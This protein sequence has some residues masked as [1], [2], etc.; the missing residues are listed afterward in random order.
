MKRVLRPVFL[1]ATVVVVGGAALV[2]QTTRTPGSEMAAAAN[3][4]LNSLTPELKQKASFA[5]DDPHRTAWFFTPQQDAMRQPTRKGVR[6]EELSAEQRTAVLALLK[7]GLSASGYDQATTIMSLESVLNTLEKNGRNVRNPNWYFVSIFGTPSTTGQWG[8]RFEGHHMSINFTLDKG[9]V[10]TATPTLFGANPAEI[11]SGPMQ[12]KRTLSA[13]EDHAKKLIASLSPQQKKK[14]LQPKQ[15]PEIQE[16]SPT[17]D[18]GPA[19][20]LP[21]AQLQADQQAIL[22]KLLEAYAGRLEK[23]VAQNELAAVKKAGFE[24]VTFAYHIAESAPGKPYTYR[25]Q[26]PTF[27]VEFLNVQKDAAGNPANHIHSAWRRLPIDFGLS[28]AAGTK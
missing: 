17:A 9:Q 14:A 12:G 6:M 10:V 2:A 27:V 5:Y 23:S 8:W 21:A 4:M 22:W 16:N 28:V 11:R 26:G 24:K 25:V 19:V 1:I 20:G 7:A 3:A 18:V 15:L 13:I